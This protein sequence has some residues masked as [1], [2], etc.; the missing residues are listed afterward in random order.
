M[1]ELLNWVLNRLSEKSTWL[2]IVGILSAFGVYVSPDLGEAI[3]TAGLAVGSAIAL[4]IKDKGADDA[5]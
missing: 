3:A 4:F 1:D 5:P 2:G